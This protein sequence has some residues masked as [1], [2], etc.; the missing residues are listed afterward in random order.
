MNL[1]PHFTLAEFTASQTAARRGIVNTPP[2]EVLARLKVTAAGMEKV[3]AVLGKPVTVSSAYRSPA[4][5][6][7][8]GGAKNSAHVEGWA[9][10]FNCHAYGTPLEVARKIQSAGI[11]YDQIIYEFGPR[12]WVHI[13][14]DPRMRGQELTVTSHGTTGGLNE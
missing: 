13:S 9:V 1:S 12:G 11:A 7:A 6:K 2:P 10:D 5:N 4:L 8:V 14:F 3:R